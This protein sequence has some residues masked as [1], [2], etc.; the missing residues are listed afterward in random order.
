M[1]TSYYWVV[2]GMVADWTQ[3]GAHAASLGCD[4]IILAA[5]DER[6]RVSKIPIYQDLAPQPGAS[7]ELPDP[8]FDNA[9]RDASRESVEKDVA[10]AK[11]RGVTGFR[12]LT[13]QLLSA[14]DWAAIISSHSDC[15]F[16]AWTPGLPPDELASLAGAGFA[17]V[18]D[19]L[20]WWD[21]RRAWY[22]EEAW[23]LAAVAPAIATLEAPGAPRSASSHTEN[24][25]EAAARLRIA[26][27]GNLGAG[28]LVPMGYEFGARHP[29]DAARGTAEEW[30]WLQENAPYDLSG[31]LRDANAAIASRGTTK[32]SLM[33]VS[34]PDTAILA[35]LRHTAAGSQST[36]ILANTDPL[37]TLTLDPGAVPPDVS[38]ALAGVGRL[39]LHGAE[40]RTLSLP[41]PTSILGASRGQDGAR[42]AAAAPRVAIEA[43]RPSVDDGR[44][45]VKRTLGENVRVEV[46]LITDGHEK[47]G[48]VLQWRAADETEWQELRLAPSGNDR[49]FAEFP[50]LRLGAYRFRI[51][52]W[53]DAFASFA[54]GLAKN[55]KA[56][57]PVTL[58]LEEGRLLLA[59][60]AEGKSGPLAALATRLLAADEAERLAVL[61]SGE[62]AALMAAADPRPL[63]AQSGEYGVDSER[64]AAGFAAWYELFPRSQAGD[65]KR[66]GTFA[67]VIAQLP[68]IQA[69]GFDTLYFPPIHPIGMKARKGRNNSLTAAPDDPGSP[70]GIGA[71]EG[72]HDALHPELGTLED[73]ARLRAA[74][75][76]HGLEL[77]IDFAIQCSLDHPWLKAHPGWFDWRPD[78]S[79]RTAENPPKKYEDIVNV[80][81]YAEDA[82]PSLWLA[83]RDVVLFWA[84]QGVRCFRVD[85]PH[86]KP[87]PFWEWMIAEVRAAYP[88]ALFLAEAFTRPKLMYRLAKLGFSQSYTYFTW[89]NTKVELTDYLTE[90]TTTAPRDFFRPHFFVNTPDINPFFLQTGGRP[91]HLIRA[92]LAAT[93]SGLWGVYQGFEY[94]EAAALP[95]REEYLNSEKYQLRAWP[96][97]AQGDIVDEIARLNIIRKTN[98]AM[99]SHLTLEF[100]DAAND[101][102]LWYRKATPDRSNVVFCAVSLD[103]HQVQESAVDL[104]LWQWSLPDDGSVEVEDLFTGER[105]RWQGRRQSLRIDPAVRPF[106]IYR[107]RPAEAA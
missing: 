24:E 57:V 40:V 94:C 88:D 6:A 70:Y 16:L 41:A 38:P 59:K 30:E 23:R 96:D 55:S 80:D 76:E 33:P 43:E 12:C 3:M 36:L 14:A 28:M 79:L 81:F 71:A 77:A 2:P 106:A 32:A 58:S 100:H 19:S 97:R 78:G 60:A 92:A 67:D 105:F 65:G 61:Q 93:L 27:A 51:Q 74:A 68:R 20:A 46:D 13:P 37:R 90:L 25:R 34:G 4:A 85:N 10:D 73:F 5:P 8:R 21:A 98:P 17:N 75:A 26:L 45:A 44:F 15:R 103:P 9:E 87:L 63:L 83:L 107:I 95:G 1:P 89:R 56:G 50:L 101:Q 54:D 66:H 53:P 99:R 52:A 48:A 84:E 18:F 104:P 35:L 102:V 82:I 91:G 39:S 62:T 42:D 49:W 11:A 72:G 31:A 47:I 29:L 22:V 7:A 64:T 86:T 69:M